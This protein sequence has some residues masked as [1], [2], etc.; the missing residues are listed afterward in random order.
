MNLKNKQKK[1]AR[2]ILFL[3]FFQLKNDDF[4]EM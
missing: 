2:N 4:K 3:F 1:K